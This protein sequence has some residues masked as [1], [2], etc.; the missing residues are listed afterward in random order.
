MV[1]QMIWIPRSKKEDFDQPASSRLSVQFMYFV[2]VRMCAIG[3]KHI[4]FLQKRLE[5]SQVLVGT[6]NIKIVLV[7]VGIYTVPHT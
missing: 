6:I 5:N 3:R 1:W 7:L 4:A 2:C